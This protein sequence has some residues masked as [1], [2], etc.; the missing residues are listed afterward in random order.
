MAFETYQIVWWLL[1]GVVLFLIALTI[2]FDFGVAALMPFLS[3]KDLERRTV[4]N[5]VGSTW[6]G[7]Q[8]WLVMGGGTIYAIWP[9]IYSTA[10]SGFYWAMILLL[11]ALYSRPIVF[12]WRAKM[13]QPRTKSIMDWSIALGSMFAAFAI[14]LLIG[15]LF[16][17]VPY[18]FLDGGRS[19]YTGTLWQLF[20]PLALAFAF[21][22]LFLLLL[23]GATYIRLTVDRLVSDRC[24]STIRLFSLLFI[25]GFAG[26]GVWLAHGVV[27]MQLVKAAGIHHTDKNVVD[28][29]VGHWMA[30]YQRFAW[31][32]IFP[33]V[34]FFG[35]VLAFITAKG[36]AIWGFVGSSLAAFGSVFTFGGSL[37]PFLMPSSSHPSESLTVWDAT[38]SPHTLHVMFVAAMIF[39]PII[40]LYTLYVYLK[41]SRRLTLSD[42]QTDPSLY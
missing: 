19:V 33:A 15:N 1:I 6:A 8:I 9:Q 38:S 37:F 36:K 13:K 14:G 41:M 32:V 10:F 12:E 5:S 26:I 35:A 4:L 18:H 30:N 20:N 40:L 17:G 23:H 22:S 24:S 3:K 25:I 42:V 2:G 34:G 39:I 31:F 21:T 16:K 7:N 27:G 28:L 11:W 29:A